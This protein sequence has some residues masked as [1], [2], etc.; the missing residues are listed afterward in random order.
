MTE[1]VTDWL[2]RHSEIVKGRQTDNK[3]GMKLEQPSE[4]D[5]V[6]T[7]TSDTK[8]WRTWGKVFVK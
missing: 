7:L 3:V 2:L 8:R 6:H 1:L 4:K 5:G